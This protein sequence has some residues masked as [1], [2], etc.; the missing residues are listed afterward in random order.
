MTR[1][2]LDMFPA[3]DDLFPPEPVVYRADPD[4]VRRKLERILAEAR[5]AETMPWD[6]SKH[7]L[8]A[9]IVPQMTLWLPDDEAAQFRL[10]FAAE[11]E[12]LG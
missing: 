2:Q 11:M 8:Y 5:A 9:T 3:Q 7:A 1:A 6:R 4:K 12:R 10:D